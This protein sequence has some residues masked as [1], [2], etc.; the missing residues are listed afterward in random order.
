MSEINELVLITNVNPS[1]HYEKILHYISI[2]QKWILKV[3]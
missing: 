3:K 1:C 2:E